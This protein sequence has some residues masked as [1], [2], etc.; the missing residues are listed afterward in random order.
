ML[1]AALL[2]DG[3]VAGAFSDGACLLVSPDGTAFVAME[4]PTDDA[5]AACFRHASRFCV[6]K[7]RQRLRGLLRLRNAFRNRP[8]VAAR[9]GDTVGQTTRAVAECAL[10]R[11]AV[12]RRDVAV[13]RD[14]DG[15]HAAQHVVSLR[16]PAASGDAWRAAPAPEPIVDVG[17]PD[18]SALAAVPHD[19]FA[20]ARGEKWFGAA[21]IVEWTPQATIFVSAC[22][23]HQT[24]IEARLQGV[25]DGFDAAHVYQSRVA[26]VLFLRGDGACAVRC[27]QRL[28]DGTLDDCELAEDAA[29]WVPSAGFDGASALARLVTF[30]DDFR[31]HFRGLGRSEA[32]RDMLG[33][34]DAAPLPKP[35]R[36]STRL[37]ERV[38]DYRGAALSAF[39]DG[40]VR[41]V[42]GDRVVAE[43]D[44]AGRFCDAL[45]AD[46]TR[47]RVE[48]RDPGA[49]GEHVAVLLDFQAWAR[50]PPAQRDV[51]TLQRRDH[52]AQAAAAAEASRRFVGSHARR[53]HARAAPSE[54]PKNLRDAA[55]DALGKTAALLLRA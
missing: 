16:L 21:A 5:P 54:S 53:S 24:Q 13:P 47:L 25:S 50:S 37:V 4:P 42:F 28:E 38:A 29:A 31:A 26:L 48:A 7:W 35:P 34:A 51:E 45:L 33:V 44:A 39:A 18:H 19:V 22:D 41:G 20:W 55:A 40:R 23:G 46:A 27:I 10:G 14:D 32:L 52:L 43:V 9:L 15:A 3:V 8:Y 30:G 36:L 1:R 12:L 11:L 6:S 2:D 17:A 49:L